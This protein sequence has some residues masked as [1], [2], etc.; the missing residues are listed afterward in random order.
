MHKMIKFFAALS[1]AL[2]ALPLIAST[3][4]VITHNV[5]KDSLVKR[6]TVHIITKQI[7]DESFVMELRYSIVAKVLFFERVLDGT[8]SVE[9]SSRYLSPYG[10]EELEEAGRMED[11]K[12][13]VIHM[14]RKNLPNH[15]DCHVIK[16]IPKKE[17]R[18]DGVFTYCQ[19]IPSVGFARTK[20]NMR[21]IPWVGE[22]T[23][24]TRIIE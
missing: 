4:E 22:H 5:Q 2:V 12:I 3:P 17:R 20:I 19:D 21:E 6:G 23:V 15:Y 24:H 9:L 16:I 14:G 1:A 8:K 18:W 10:Y 11:E 7:K 13:T